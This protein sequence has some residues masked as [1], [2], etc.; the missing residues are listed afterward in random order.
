MTQRFVRACSGDRVTEAELQWSERPPWH[1]VLRIPTSIR[2]RRR[3]MTYLR[4]WLRYGSKLL[5]V[6]GGSALR[7]REQTLGR[8]A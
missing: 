3:L 1:L 8:R 2:L 7:V 5:A 6:D 4:A